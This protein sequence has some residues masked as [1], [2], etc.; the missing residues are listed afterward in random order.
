MEYAVLVESKTDH[1]GR[2]PPRHR[3]VYRG[4]SL[5]FARNIVSHY[6]RPID[7]ISAWIIE[8]ATEADGLGWIGE[9]ALPHP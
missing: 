6:Q 4:D 5:A 7:G 2:T 1:H 9:R 8:I 3:Y